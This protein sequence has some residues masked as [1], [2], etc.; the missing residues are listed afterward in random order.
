M[1]HKPDLPSLTEMRKPETIA[2]LRP[3]ESI[4]DAASLRP[5]PADL[6]V[7]QIR[8]HDKSASLSTPGTHIT[9]PGISFVLRNKGPAHFDQHQYR[10][11]VVRLLVDNRP[12]PGYTR[13]EQLADYAKL[14]KPGSQFTVVIP[15]ELPK[16]VPV[17]IIVN[18]NSPESSAAAKK[19]PR[20]AEKPSTWQPPLP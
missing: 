20:L 7:E 9:Q 18:S 16:R 15:V 11:S 8:Y 1:P 3:T 13:M 6:S 4:A 5:L 12:V 2:P 19:P 10:P 17:A 14:G